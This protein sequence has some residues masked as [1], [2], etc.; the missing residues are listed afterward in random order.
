MA[1]STVDTAV[2]TPWIQDNQNTA[3]WMNIDDIELSNDWEWYTCIAE[4]NES[5]SD[6]YKIK[7][8][9]YEATTI[10]IDSVR[11]GFLDWHSQTQMKL[12]NTNLPTWLPSTKSAK[13]S[14]NKELINEVS[15][16]EVFTIYPNPVKNVLTINGEKESINYKIFNQQGVLV[17]Q[18][19]EKQIDVTALPAGLYVLIG[20]NGKHAKFIKR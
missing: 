2:I 20:D 14:S 5:T 3:N 18:R 16:N 13:I 6:Y 9:G 11:V 12:I 19:Q 17:L 15:V 10:N 8:K 7:F 4:M 1:K